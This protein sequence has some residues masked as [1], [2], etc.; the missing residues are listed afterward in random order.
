MSSLR[1]RGARRAAH[2]CR[3]QTVD[4]LT[5]VVFQPFTAV[6]PARPQLPGMGPHRPTPTAPRAAARRIRVAVQVKG[7]LATVTKT[8]SEKESFARVNFH[9]ECEGAINEQ[10]K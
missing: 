5:G 9:P 3:A 1:R 8:D 4:Q 7:E 6:S 10:I 2:T